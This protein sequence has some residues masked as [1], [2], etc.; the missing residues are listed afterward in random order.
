MREAMIIPIDTTG[1]FSFRMKS[2][3][4]AVGERSVGEQV[5]A[6]INYRRHMHYVLGK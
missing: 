6:E 2:W 3:P 1:E 4:G 5:G